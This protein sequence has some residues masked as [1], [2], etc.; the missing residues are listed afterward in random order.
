MF[1]LAMKR[2]LESLPPTPCSP[3]FVGNRAVGCRAFTCKC[4]CTHVLCYSV[5]DG[6]HGVGC[7]HKYIKQVEMNKRGPHDVTGPVNICVSKDVFAIR[8]R[9]V[10]T[11][12]RIKH[13]SAPRRPSLT[14]SS[15]IS[16]APVSDSATIYSD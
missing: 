3:L 4:S 15:R 5:F 14:T 13:T 10:V 12:D 2:T 8:R 11:G 9:R 6:G 1:F 7:L 16:R